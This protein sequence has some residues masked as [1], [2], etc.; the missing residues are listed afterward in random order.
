M[1]TF[2]T[3]PAP[4]DL[5][6]P[7]E[8][9][10]HLRDV[11]LDA[12]ARR[13]DGDLTAACDLLAA[14]S[15]PG[16]VVALAAILAGHAGW[17]SG[18]ELPVRALIETR[19]PGTSE[20]LA[21]AARDWPRDD[22]ALAYLCRVLAAR[23]EPEGLDFL[24]ELARETA[25]GEPRAHPPA[26]RK[27]L[28]AL[29]A[30]EARD[31]RAAVARA[32]ERPGDTLLESDLL[33]AIV[34]ASPPEAAFQL[35]SPWFGR[36]GRSRVGKI[37]SELARHAERGGA[38]DP[39]WRD[40]VLPRYLG[41][42]TSE[43]RHFLPQLVAATATADDLI[44]LLRGG[45][46]APLFVTALARTRDRSAGAV[47]CEVI[48]HEQTPKLAVAVAAAE[49]L[50]LEGSLAGREQRALALALADRASATVACALEAAALLPIDDRRA[51]LKAALAERRRAEPAEPDLERIRGDVLVGE[52]LEAVGGEPPE[53]PSAPTDGRYPFLFYGVSGVDFFEGGYAYEVRFARRLSPAERPVALALLGHGEA[54]GE[55]SRWADDWLLAE[56]RRPMSPELARRW[57]ER[58]RALHV[59]LPLL[60][61][62][63]LC[64]PGRDK[65]PDPWETWTLARQPVPSGAPDWRRPMRPTPFE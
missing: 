21:R 57:Q 23:R 3:T 65:P 15:N 4:T 50:R 42:D 2:P 12:I 60:E 52:A 40:V 59:E 5:P 36:E 32:L 20:L 55:R 48:L 11:G 39:R 49:L 8:Q 7:S 51:T 61:A 6:A 58:L 64:W 9:E 19:W 45:D 41:G 17:A 35:L 38:L 63:G 29:A 46:R 13:S 26:H 44:D 22:L 34:V 27:A 28:C 37:A 43:A 30:F 25:P 24:L 62:H 47:L 18:H 31:A 1:P 33:R 54:E 53:P 56:S 14:A 10:A 16:S